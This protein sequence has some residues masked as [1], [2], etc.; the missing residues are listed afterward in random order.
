MT[1]LESGPAWNVEQLI[2][3][4][5]GVDA[6]LL[7]DVRETDEFDAWHIPGAVL[8]PLGE[9]ADRLNEIPRDRQL[10]TV[11]AAG[12]RAS[13]GAEIL[14]SAGYAVSVLSGGMESWGQAYETV[15]SFLGGATIVQIRRRGKGC[16]SYVIGSQSRAV[17]IDPS[18]EIT[19]YL[20][21][22]AQFGFEITHVF[23]THL[24][25]DHLSG[26]RALSEA[27]GATLLL[28]PADPFAYDF[29]PIVHDLRIEISDDLHLTVSAVSTP[30]HTEGSTVYRLGDVAL[31]TGD[32][33]FLESVGRPDLADQA[34]AFAH[35]LYRSLHEVV[36]KL[37]DEML[38]F[39]AHYGDAVEVHY[40]E[41][42]TK[43]L[44]NLRRNL[45]ALA[46]DEGT[47][48]QWAVSRVTDRPPNYMEIVR[49]NA[50]RSEKSL[51]ELRSL[52]L[53]P[54]RCAIAS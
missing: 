15:T 41:L 31:F 33:L 35:S 37:P 45:P 42:V 53:G 6:P 51:D 46:Y 50:G 34:E 20:S 30:G 9:L 47:F 14:A 40:G 52:E 32:T 13:K 8:F 29:T 17:V 18:V 4:L 2:E 24:H 43:T 48:V 38:I 26:A 12:L 25:A 28:N 22:A 27:T 21:V 19:R 39:P 5:D 1:I 7:I 3:R 10:V 16:L 36:L 11:C 54:N 44:G 23:D 49:F